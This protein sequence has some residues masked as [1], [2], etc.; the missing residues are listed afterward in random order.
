MLS[1]IRC[2]VPESSEAIVPRGESTY[3]EVFGPAVPA[4]AWR[5]TLQRSETLGLLLTRHGL[6]PHRRHAIIQSMRS[7][8]DLRCCLPGVTLTAYGDSSTLNQIIYR[9]KDRA[10]SIGL[11]EDSVRV[12][13]LPFSLPRRISFI[14]GTVSDNLYESMRRSGCSPAL[15][16]RFADVFAW[17]VDFLT[18]VRNGDQF[19]LIFEESIGR[20]YSNEYTIHAAWYLGERGERSAIHYTPSEGMAA[21]F[22]ENG[23]SVIRTFLRSPLN[24]SRISSGFSFSRMHPILRIPR[25]HL[26]VDY[27]APTGTPVV[28]IADGTVTSAGWRNGFGKT[29]LIRHAGSCE[30]QYAHLSRYGPGIR[31]GAA[32]VQGQVI[33]YVGSTG[34]STG[35][36]LD[37]RF[38]KAGRW[39][40]PLTVDSPRAEPVPEKDLTRYKKIAG[41]YVCVLQDFPVE[42]LDTA[43]VIGHG[44]Y[45][46]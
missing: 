12:Q 39:V 11:E 36:H 6:P 17:D 2:G 31:K 43:R 16:L 18:E 10:L 3:P 40:N 27:A 19:A 25:P 35:P 9:G 26:G 44:S 24:F 41:G 8:M 21:Y 30:T 28:S 15:I 14:R 29:V 37:F 38:R 22:N 23:E 20:L 7:V 5:D 34:L 13:E 45:G 1:L 32:V 4:I 46:S 33:G 42:W